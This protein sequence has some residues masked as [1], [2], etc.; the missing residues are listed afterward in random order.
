MADRRIGNKFALGL[1]TNGR[2]PEYKKVSDIE[3]KLEEYFESL[4]DEEGNQYITRPTMTGMALF[5]GFASRQ[6]MYD[7]S[8][9]NDFSYIITRAQQVIAMSYEEMLLSKVSSGAIFA[10][11]NMGWQDKTEVEQT[12]KNVDIPLSEWVNNTDKGAES[13]DNFG[14]D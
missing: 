9:K 2:P 6:S 10:L 1:T 5:L 11:K 14:K 7:Y 4:L 8:K 3:D 12:N 13:M